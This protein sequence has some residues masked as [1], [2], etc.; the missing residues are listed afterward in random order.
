MTQTFSRRAALGMTIVTG[1]ALIAFASA[2]GL[3]L[4]HI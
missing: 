1:L 4:I 2:C 3:S